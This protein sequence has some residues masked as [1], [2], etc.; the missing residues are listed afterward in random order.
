MFKHPGNNWRALGHGHTFSCRSR[1]S[2]WSTVQPT[3][4]HVP[5]IS[6]MVPLRSRAQLR[7]L[8]MRAISITSSMEML[9]LWRMFFS[10]DTTRE[11]DRGQH[12]T[13]TAARALKP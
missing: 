3:D 6:R 11:R 8:M 10:C 13:P 7:S 9:P 5:R 1:G 2:S 12:N 4:T